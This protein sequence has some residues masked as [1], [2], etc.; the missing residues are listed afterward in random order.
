MNVNTFF[1]TLATACVF[2][3]ASLTSTSTS[4][5]QAGG[6]TGGPT[7]D[8]NY[9][10]G[11]HALYGQG[12]GSSFAGPITLTPMTVPDIGTD[13]LYELGNGVPGNQA[14]LMLGLA[15]LNIDLTPIGAWG[16]RLLVD[17]LLSIPKNINALGMAEFEFTV[18]NNPV[19]IGTHLFAQGVAVDAMANAFGLVLTNGVDS[20]IG[21]TP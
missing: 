16:C 10:P 6:P 12:C 21:G 19:F 11:V 2:G 7:G 4:A 14:W 20:S 5:A 13:I 9:I 15:P 18:P 17:P 1:R 3:L 8:P